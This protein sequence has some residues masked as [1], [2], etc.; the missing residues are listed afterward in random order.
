MSVNEYYRMF[1]DL[2]RYDPEV[3]ANPVE[4]LRRFSLVKVRMRKEKMGARDEMTKENGKHFKDPARPRTL[5][6][7]V[8]VPALLADD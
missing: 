3:A 2:S 6:G 7:V 4:M 1:T 8:A 5:R